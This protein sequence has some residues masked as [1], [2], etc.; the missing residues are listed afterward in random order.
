M[1]L[2]ISDVLTSMVT[3]YLT[4]ICDSM[5][6]TI[7]IEI[8]KTPEHH[9][10]SSGT[11]ISLTEEKKIEKDEPRTEEVSNNEENVQTE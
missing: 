8:F 3:R 1:K 11:N 2:S 6:S 5:R 7:L 10:P 9:E 4:E